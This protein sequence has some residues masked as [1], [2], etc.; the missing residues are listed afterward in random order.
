MGVRS[1]WVEEATVDGP[2]DENHGDVYFFCAPVLPL[3]I[4][5]ITMEPILH[6]SPSPNHHSTY[7]K[8]TDDL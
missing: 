8:I 4:R 7:A 1:V 3:E 6:F 5:Y 2:E